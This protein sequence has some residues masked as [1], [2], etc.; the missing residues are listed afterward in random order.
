MSAIDKAP[1]G[2]PK[3]DDKSRTTLNERLLRAQLHAAEV[4]ELQLA[5]RLAQQRAREAAESYDI[6]RAWVNEQHGL[7]LG[8]GQGWDMETGEVREQPNA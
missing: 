7:K 2:P 6:A 3:L 5:L 4:R 8:D 1:A